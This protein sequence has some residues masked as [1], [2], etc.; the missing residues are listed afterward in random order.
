MGKRCLTAVKQMTPAA[1]V[2]APEALD[3][4]KRSGQRRCDVAFPLLMQCM[5]HPGHCC[6]PQKIINVPVRFFIPAEMTGDAL[7]QS[8]HGGAHVGVRARSEYKRAEGTYLHGC[9][10][11]QRHHQHVGTRGVRRHRASH[12]LPARCAPRCLRT[13]RLPPMLRH[14]RTVYRHRRRQRRLHR[15]ARRPRRER[16]VPPLPV[17]RRPA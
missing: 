3:G 14:R 11:R 17:G 2:T 16:R 13:R 10:S 1:A 5:P 4:I 8:I 12:P 9:R 15:V 6:L 7:P